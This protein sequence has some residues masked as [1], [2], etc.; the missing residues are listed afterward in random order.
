ME[1]ELELY[2][3]TIIGGGPAGMYAAF[4]SG[5]RDM[6]TKLIEANTELGGRLQLYKEKTI[7]D[8]GGLTPIR[9][10]QLI[11]QLI[12]QAHTFE[13]TIVL[14]QQIAGLERLAD[15]TMLLTA[16]TGE[17][18]YTRTLILAVGY[19]VPHP[20]KLELEGAE[21]YEAA[22]LHYTVTD[23]EHFRGKRVLLS[24]GSDTAVDWALALEPIAAEVTLVHR[25]AALGGHEKNVRRILESSI[26]VLTPYMLTELHGEE[27][28][29]QAVT[30]ARADADGKPTAESELIEVDAILI[31]HGY[32]C[33]LGPIRGWQLA[34][35]EYNIFGGERMATNLPGVFAAGDTVTH[36]NK[37]RLI[38]GAFNDAAM[39][40]NG[41]KLYL[42]PAAAGMAYVTSHN[43]KLKEKNKALRLAGKRA[44]AGTGD[45]NGVADADVDEDDE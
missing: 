40:V 28:L 35:D 13:P 19:G 17:R 26:R 37:L 11:G 42:E 8:V 29:L 33:D 44:G 38:A 31:N 24:G 15:G 5:M 18:H 41:A 36:P 25:R 6:K 9:C 22:N 4:Y 10:E 12:A 3:V 21:R 20:A 7:W 16:A 39:A 45:A 2:D 30:I 34:M 23:L 27:D 1:T 32:A 43:E 14:G